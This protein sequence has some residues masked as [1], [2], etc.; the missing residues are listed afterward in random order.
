VK[1][2]LRRLTSLAFLV[3]ARTYLCSPY[4]LLSASSSSLSLSHTHTKRATAPK[5]PPFVPPSHRATANRASPS[6]FF[7]LYSKSWPLK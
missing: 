5:H 2:S 1:S 4:I 3:T 7:L 6:P